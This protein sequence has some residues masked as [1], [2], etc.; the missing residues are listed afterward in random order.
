MAPIAE[1]HENLSDKM[2]GNADKSKFTRHFITLKTGFKPTSKNL[3]V[4]YL[5]FTPCERLIKSTLSL[6]LKNH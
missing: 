1:I 5:F 4:I 6:Y 3:G 2:N